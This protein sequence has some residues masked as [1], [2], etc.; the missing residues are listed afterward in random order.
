MGVEQGVLS[1]LTVQKNNESIR[2]VLILNSKKFFERGHLRLYALSRLYAIS[3]PGV[4]WFFFYIILCY[5]INVMIKTWYISS[6]VVVYVVF[7]THNLY[8]CVFMC[9][10]LLQKD[11]TFSARNLSSPAVFDL[12]GW[13]NHHF[14]GNWMQ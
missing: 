2:T 12:D 7:F 1:V 8:S 9:F 13:I 11:Y 3:L 10:S 6:F 4:G 14:I 5:F